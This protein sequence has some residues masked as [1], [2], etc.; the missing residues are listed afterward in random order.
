MKVALE[1]ELL[2]VNVK[3]PK[4]MIS[5]E[6]GSKDR[7]EVFKKCFK[8]VWIIKIYSAIRARLNKAG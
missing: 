3:K 4:I 7:K 2:R 5:S 1:S 8:S 6:K